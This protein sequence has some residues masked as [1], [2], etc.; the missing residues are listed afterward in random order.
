[1]ASAIARTMQSQ[2]VTVEEATRRHFESMKQE[3]PALFA[4]MVTRRFEQEGK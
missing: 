1:M 2:G 3:W 4:A